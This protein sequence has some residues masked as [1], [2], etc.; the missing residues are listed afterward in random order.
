MRCEIRSTAT[1][2]GASAR[3]P[4]AAAG[5]QRLGQ[6]ARRL[7]EDQ[8]PR[9]RGDGARDLDLLLELDAQL[10]DGAPLVD[11]HVEAVEDLARVGAQP[12][13]VDA[14]QPRARQPADEDVLRDA[15]GRRQR[16]LLADRR[17]CRSSSASSAS[18]IV[19][20]T[21]STSIRPASG[22]RAPEAISRERRLPRAVLAG[23][24]CTTPAWSVRPTSS[25]ATTPGK[26]LVIPARRS[27]GGR[28]TL[29][30][31]SA[32]Q[33]DHALEPARERGA[34]LAAVDG[35]RAVGVDVEREAARHDD[36]G[37]RELDDRWAV[38]RRGD[39][40]PAAVPYG[41]GTSARS[42]GS[43]TGRSPRRASGRGLVGPA[44]RAPASRCARPRRC[45]ARAPRSRRARDAW[46]NSR[47]CSAWKA[48][49]AA[50]TSS[51]S[52]MRDGQLVPLAD[53]AEVERGAQLDG[54]IGHALAGERV[55][56]AP[57][58]S[59]NSARSRSGSASRAASCIRARGRA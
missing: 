41:R 4:P 20:S 18:A 28:R 53:V 13:P 12:G 31:P 51:G 26:R 10:A 5:S 55:A 32:G 3:P 9:R 54:L 8:H 24:A 21:P 22:V 44:P 35:E 33:H 19:R 40:Q 52:S 25:S 37:A 29:H 45:A 38:D 39:R 27:S 30:W 42:S 15:Q 56:P 23:E 57:L 34:A 14:A 2:R 36:R 58:I 11:A 50:S 46:P 6:R 43:H 49:A 17:R 7:V 59:S 1:L 48:A 16:E 47:S